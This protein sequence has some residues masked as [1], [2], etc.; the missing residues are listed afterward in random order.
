MLQSIEG[1]LLFYL[2]KRKNV[3]LQSFN[4]LSSAVF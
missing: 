4:S 2:L 1:G 3:I